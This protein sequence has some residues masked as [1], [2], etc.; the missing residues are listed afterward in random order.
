MQINKN[1]NLVFKKPYYEDRT[2]NNIMQEM[3]QQYI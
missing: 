2:K 1:G 3:V